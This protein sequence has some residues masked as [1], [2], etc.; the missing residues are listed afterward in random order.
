MLPTAR[1]IWLS[2]S[3]RQLNAPDRGRSKSPDHQ[4]A[5][6]ILRS[7]HSSRYDHDISTAYDTDCLFTRYNSTGQIWHSGRTQIRGLVKRS[8]ARQHRQAAPPNSTDGAPLSLLNRGDGAAPLL[9][10]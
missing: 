4:P 6:G 10:A 5:V 1:W 8:A 7:R 2:T 3:P 9:P